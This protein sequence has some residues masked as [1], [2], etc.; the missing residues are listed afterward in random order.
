[1]EEAVRKL[2]DRY[3]Q[4]FDRALGGDI[5]MDEVAGLYATAFIGTPRRP[6]S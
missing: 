2:F 5:D 4:A 3:A 6:G 1:M